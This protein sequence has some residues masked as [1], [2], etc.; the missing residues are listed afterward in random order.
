MK[1]SSPVS[2]VK[3]VGLGV[4]LAAIVNVI[5]FTI[6][7]RGAHVQIIAKTGNPP[8]DLAVGR[9]IGATVVSMVLG[10]IGLLIVRR[11]KPNG[12][13][14]WASGAAILAVLTISGPMGLKIATDSKIALALMHLVT[15]AAAIFSQAVMTRGGNKSTT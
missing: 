12:F 1:I 15:G 8:T 2:I 3:G 9:V 5:I 11:I 14:L 13:T 7:N 10:G 4:V 6:G